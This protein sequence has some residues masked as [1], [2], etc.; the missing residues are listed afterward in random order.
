MANN[1]TKYVTFVSMSEPVDTQEPEPLVSA[2]PADAK[3]KSLLGPASPENQEAQEDLAVILTLAGKSLV[4]SQYEP[5]HRPVWGRHLSCIQLSPYYC[6]G[7][8]YNYKWH[9]LYK[10]IELI[11][12][13]SQILIS[14]FAPPGG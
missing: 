7:C 13:F 12:T 4:A 2:I 11:M 14:C 5:K 9:S 3:Q 6:C 1:F 8:Y 10:T